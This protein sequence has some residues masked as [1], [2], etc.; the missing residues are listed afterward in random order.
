MLR[1]FTATSRSMSAIGCSWNGT[2]FGV[3][4]P[5]LLYITSSRPKRS[6][7]AATSA[8]TSR[9]SVASQWTNSASP[10]AL[11]TRAT[12]SF[13]QSSRRSATATRAPW[14]ANSSAAARPTPEPEPVITATRSRNSSFT[15]RS[16][17]RSPHHGHRGGH[18]ER[19]AGDVG[20]R[21]GGIE[22]HVGQAVQHRFERG[23]QLHARKVHADAEVRA[24]TE[25]GVGLWRP[26]DVVAIGLV[27]PR[28]V[29]VRRPEGHVHEAAARHAHTGELAVARRQ[30]CHRRQ[31]LLPPQPLLDR[32]LEQ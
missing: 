29:V 1:R 15:T 20:H 12:V 8:S 5:T 10:P 17:L 24:T 6:T 23:L 11:S 27:P 19:E 9:S 28:G 4:M 21:R 18:P 13:P 14:R 32:G 26:P 22:S 31:R 2:R 16:L 3:A 7:A 25:R 30:P